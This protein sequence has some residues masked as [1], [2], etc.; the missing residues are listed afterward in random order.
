MNA[1]TSTLKVTV[2]GKK[3]LITG[4]QKETSCK[5][6]L[7]AIAK[8]TSLEDSSI[9]SY[10]PRS[11]DISNENLLERFKGDRKQAG[12]LTSFNVFNTLAKDAKIIAK[13]SSLNCKEAPQEPGHSKHSSKHKSKKHK[14]EKETKI[15]EDKDK[16]KDKKSKQKH[17]KKETLTTTTTTLTTRTTETKIKHKVK[18]RSVDDSDIESYKRDNLKRMKNKRR[19]YDDSD[20]DTYKTLQNIVNDQNK[21]LHRIQSSSRE[22]KKAAWMKELKRNS[23][24]YYID[25][26][27]ELLELGEQ[28]VKMTENESCS[29]EKDD[30]NDS[31]LPSPE[32][33]SSEST[34]NQPI[35]II[36]T[37]PLLINDNNNNEKYPVAS[38]PKQSIVNDQNKSQIEQSEGGILPNVDSVNVSNNREKSCNSISAEERISL[39][40]NG[41]K[42]ETL[43]ENSCEV[44]ERTRSEIKGDELNEISNALDASH[45]TVNGDTNTKDIPQQHMV[46][47]VNETKIKKS[48]LTP[49][50][51]E[52]YKTMM[53]DKNKNILKDSDT[54]E[55]EVS[56]MVAFNDAL[57]KSSNP[58]TTNGI[59]K[60]MEKKK[61]KKCDIS[62]PVLLSPTTL[63]KHHNVK[64][65]QSVLGKKAADVLRQDVVRKSFIGSVSKPTSTTE[66]KEVTKEKEKYFNKKLKEIRSKGS[67]KKSKL[68]DSKKEPEYFS[69]SQFVEKPLTNSNED[70]INTKLNH[71]GKALS[72]NNS[73][74]EDVVDGQITGQQVANN[75]IREKD[76][77]SVQDL[78]KHSEEM[79]E[80]R[81]RQE[82]LNES[83]VLKADEILN[84]I[85]EYEKNIKNELDQIIQNDET[86]R[87]EE[88]T[89][90][91]NQGENFSSKSAKVNNDESSIKEMAKDEEQ[92]H[93][94]L[95]EKYLEEKQ[96]L[97]EIEQKL[98]EYNYAITRLQEEIFLIDLESKEPKTLTDLDEEE[99]YV[100]NEI[101][102]VKS[103]IKSVIDLT[104][105]QRKEMSENMELIDQ[106][107]LD[108]RTQ[109]AN[110]D[111]LRNGTW[112]TN[113]KSAPRSLI[114]NAKVKRK[115][116]LI[117]E[118]NGTSNSR[119]NFV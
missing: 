63:K 22:V 119:S 51:Q 28:A 84:E 78:D 25:D 24:I 38:K 49:V 107:D 70:E 118:A 99:L 6:L 90:T 15:K 26:Q 56:K 109:K 4:I 7:C 87:K 66:N 93:F 116:S 80:A 46:D 33:D 1:S 17:R 91:L 97:D 86:L 113:S 44:D 95:I 13:E 11:S 62:D 40:T 106:M 14:H 115:N 5:G 71:N 110:Y 53:I 96:T 72:T 77:Q 98:N 19:T 69:K 64:K 10:S 73:I 21:K 117:A 36:E 43:N 79:L 18:H 105:Y 50:Q 102:N 31:G 111:N 29:L 35:K 94:E 3:Y 76:S 101:E 52:L 100:S 114:K 89:A 8:V 108:Y 27:P 83:D 60:K 57:F 55:R 65:V 74:L 59:G 32:Y 41:L 112:K 48:T 54:C 9:Q 103:L 20:L 88:Q 82:S 68:K 85:L 23:Q 92:I 37:V 42:K 12:D 67:S 34:E 75:P 58:S 39:S 81:L 45:N 47:A 2:N 30:G 16:K 61:F 104:N